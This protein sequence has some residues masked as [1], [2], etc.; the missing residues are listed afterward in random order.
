MGRFSSSEASSVPG[1]ETAYV[2]AAYVAAAPATRTDRVVGI[3]R[4]E[5][6]KQI[7]I[8]CR[9]GIR[10]SRVLCECT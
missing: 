9:V 8:V 7:L 2:V 6:G 1:G 4:R 5:V 10:G 3:A